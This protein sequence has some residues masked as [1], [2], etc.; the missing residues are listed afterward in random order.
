MKTWFGTGCCRRS[1]RAWEERGSARATPPEECG[2]LTLATYHSPESRR[3]TYRDNYYQSQGSAPTVSTRVSPQDIGTSLP[4][5]SGRGR[6][7]RE[8]EDIRVWWYQWTQRTIF[9]V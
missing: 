6:S 3:R 4:E 5:S 1:H 2:I 8:R 9:I 7:K